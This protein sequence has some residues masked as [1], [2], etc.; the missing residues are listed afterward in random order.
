M[1]AFTCIKK[2]NMIITYQATTGVGGSLRETVVADQ[3]YLDVFSSHS[4]LLNGAFFLQ[5]FIHIF[6]VAVVLVANVFAVNAHLLLH[7]YFVLI[8]TT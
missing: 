4:I 8:H 1:I 7:V 2:L 6:T 3:I 5:H